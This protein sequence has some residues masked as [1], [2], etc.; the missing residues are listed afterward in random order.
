MEKLRK[1]I[2]FGDSLTWGFCNYG[3]TE[4]PY[5]IKLNELLKSNGLNY[6]SYNYGFNGATTDFLNETLQQTFNDKNIQKGDIFLIYGGSNDLYSFSK[7]EIIHNLNEISKYLLKL[8]ILHFFLTLPANRCDLIWNDYGK[9]RD[10]LNDGI[11]LMY[12]K[13]KTLILDLD[14]EIRYKEYTAAERRKYWDDDVHL[15]AEGYDL[16]GTIIYKNI[17]S[18]LII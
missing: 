17:K 11:R 6:I 3:I 10:E 12:E 15:T 2:G 8:D 14:K 9:K 1:L 13:D 7:N 16:M 4:H 18:Y 5:S